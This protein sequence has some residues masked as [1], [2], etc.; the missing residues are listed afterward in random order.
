M[1]PANIK[2]RAD[3]TVKVLDFGLAK[4][5]S[6][7]SGPARQADSPTIASP[8][9]TEAHVVLGTAAYMSPEQARGRGVDARGCLPEH[10]GGGGHRASRGPVV[11][12]PVVR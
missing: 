6:S 12:R 2:V 10:D 3:G 4:A 5:L 8:A 9:Q 7:D 1:K 11:A